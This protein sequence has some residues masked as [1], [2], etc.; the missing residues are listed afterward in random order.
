MQP[1]SDSSTRLM[2]RIAGVFYLF[3]FVF[4]FMALASHGNLR[5]TANMIS[6]ASYVAVSVLFYVLFKPVN[7]AISLIAALISLTALTLGVLNMFHRDPLEINNLA[8][9][10]IYCL[11][12]GYLILKS[13]FLPRFLGVLMMIGGL[14][15]LTFALPQAKSLEPYNMVPGI[16]AE[17]VLTIWLLV[18]GVDAQRW[19]EQRRVTT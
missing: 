4:G 19:N 7:K 8:F 17:G 9:F 16:F 5:F 12:I 18:K 10:G 13:T 2:A 15:W 6:T 14:G 1:K 11:L 3:T